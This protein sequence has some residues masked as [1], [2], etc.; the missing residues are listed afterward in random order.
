MKI[1]VSSKFSNRD[2]VKKVQKKCI[3]YGHTIIEDWTNNTNSYPCSQSVE[4][5]RQNALSNYTSIRQCDAFIYLTSE[6]YGAGSSTEFGIALGL[7][8]RNGRP[9]IYVVG[10]FIDEN[11][12]FFHP[13]VKRKYLISQVL[14]EL[15]NREND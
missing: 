7:R 8:E 13:L 14:S 15:S 5:A 9:D 1:Y 4:S 12:F 11:T 6:Q 10:Q 2:E 3:G